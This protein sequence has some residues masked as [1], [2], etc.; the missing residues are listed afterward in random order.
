[1]ATQ[2][3]VQ[4]TKP[5]LYI[6]SKEYFI[7]DLFDY[8]N[9]EVKDNVFKQLKYHNTKS[10]QFLDK[11][12]KKTYYFQTGDKLSH[13]IDY[14]LFEINFFYNVDFENHVCFISETSLINLIDS[15]PNY[16]I[17][18]E[19]QISVVSKD[20]IDVSFVRED[21]N[22]IMINDY[23]DFIKK[24]LEV[25][26]NNNQGLLKQITDYLVVMSLLEDMRSLDVNIELEH[27]RHQFKPTNKSKD[28]SK[29][30][31]GRPI[32]LLERFKIADKVFDIEK[33]IRK[34]KISEAEKHQLLSLIL[35]CNEDNAK[36]IMNG[37][38]HAKVK[39]DL[40]D[41][42]IETLNL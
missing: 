42:Y 40:L 27:W 10:K 7:L 3:N 16:G 30:L 4:M 38:Y 25:K 8:I 24:F 39:D 36:K 34:L 23:E 20:L 18:K 26:G 2:N 6:P 17:N 22:E 13:E 21:F 32:N 31:N 5:N 33:T 41:E 9:K 12:S 28:K 14:E 19:N 11:M 37:Q 1:M 15:S 35:G 29:Q